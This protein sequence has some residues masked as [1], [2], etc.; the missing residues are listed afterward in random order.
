MCMF[1]SFLALT[2]RAGGKPTQNK[3]PRDQPLVARGFN[4]VRC[5]WTA[6]LA[7]SFS[8]AELMQ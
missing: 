1:E 4:R 5:G 2:R 7:F 8:A 6:Y 3:T